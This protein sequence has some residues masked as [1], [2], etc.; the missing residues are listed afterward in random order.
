VTTVA[1]QEWVDGEWVTALTITNPC[2]TETKPLRY[3]G[4]ITRATKLRVKMTA[5]ASGRVTVSLRK[6]TRAQLFV[7]PIGDEMKEVR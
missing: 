1:I 2:A 4:V 6:P 5:H 3:A 7:V